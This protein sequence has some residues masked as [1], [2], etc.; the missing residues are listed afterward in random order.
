MIL[1]VI[2]ELVTALLELLP[3]IVEAGMQIVA[4]LITGIATALPTLI[5]QIV[6][7]IVQI[8]QT[9]ID[10]LPLILVQALRL[11]QDWRKVS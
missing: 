10:N 11:S 2:T 4:S 3:Q 7:I 9:L 8:V 6:E 5:P 1:Q